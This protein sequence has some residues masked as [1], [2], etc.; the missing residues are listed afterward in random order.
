[1]IVMVWLDPR[2]PDHAELDRVDLY[3]TQYEA[4]KIALDR[5]M[6]CE[7]TVAQLIANRKS[8]KHYALDG[9]IDY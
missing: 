8:V 1:M 2:C 9:I 5:A 4:M 6:K 7:P 3:R